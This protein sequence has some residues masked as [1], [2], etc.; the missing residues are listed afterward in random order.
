MEGAEKEVSWWWSLATLGGFAGLFAVVGIIGH[1]EMVSRKPGAKEQ[2]RR[3]SMLLERWGFR[4][5]VTEYD[6]YAVVDFYDPELHRMLREV[7]A[8]YD[9]ER[10]SMFADSVVGSLEFMEAPGLLPGTYSVVV[11]GDIPMAA[12]RKPM[13][14]GFW[15]ERIQ[16]PR[17]IGVSEL[18]W[19]TED[20][21]PATHVHI[22]G[23]DVP[24]EELA[25]FVADLRNISKSFAL[26]GG[27]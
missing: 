14:R 2:A 20:G 16:I 25:G 9:R 21:L 13:A 18:H 22:S 10:A 1:Q 5:R 24:L 8:P 15:S 17:E 26:A 6:A 7:G 23:V 12:M 11:S 27:R 3:F 19:H 4:T